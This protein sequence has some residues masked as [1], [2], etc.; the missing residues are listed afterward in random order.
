MNPKVIEAQ[1]EFATLRKDYETHL[2]TARK[3]LI[4]AWLVEIEQ[5][6]TFEQAERNFRK[7]LKGSAKTRAFEKWCEL[8]TTIEDIWR[9]YNSVGRTYRYRVATRADDLLRPMVEKVSTREECERL[10]SLFP[11]Y[12]EYGRIGQLQEKV[13]KKWLPLCKT[14]HEV[15]FSDSAIHLPLTGG[16]Y[17]VRPDLWKL[18]EARLEE[19]PF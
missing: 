19:L 4:D 3:K 18:K 16:G 5:T 2:A 13:F 10:Y 12:D 1:H 9:I 6:C 8:C 17:P 14:A 11:P 7:S 15:W